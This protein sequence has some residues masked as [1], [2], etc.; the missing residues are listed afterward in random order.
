MLKVY[1]QHMAACSGSYLS[2]NHDAAYV[3]ETYSLTDNNHEVYEALRSDS[4]QF[5]DLNGNPYNFN[6]EE[7]EGQVDKYVLLDIFGGSYESPRQSIQHLLTTL[8]L[9]GWQSTKSGVLIKKIGD[10]TVFLFNNAKLKADDINGIS[11]LVNLT[12]GTLDT[13]H[14]QFFSTARADS[15]PEDIIDGITNSRGNISRLYDLIIKEQIKLRRYEMK[16]K[17]YLEYGESITAD[18]AAAEDIQGYKIRGNAVAL[19]AMKQ[20]DGEERPRL[21]YIGFDVDTGESAPGPVMA[22]YWDK[23]MYRSVDITHKTIQLLMAVTQNE[24][25]KIISICDELIDISLQEE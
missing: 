20:V 4:L 9:Y 1:L 2:T 8:Q 14:N 7:Y 23:T 24:V 21:I 10:V 5:V 18:I 15:V 12:K 3:N 19:T 13:W 25:G 6:V 11:V 22:M 17:A 16:R